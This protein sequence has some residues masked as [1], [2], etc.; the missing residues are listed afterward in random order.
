MVLPLR[1]VLSVITA[2]PLASLATVI[3]VASNFHPHEHPTLT[4]RLPGVWYQAD[5]SPAHSLFHRNKLSDR[6]TSPTVGSST[7]SAAYPEDT[8][9][10][11]QLPQ[12]WVDALDAAVSAGKIPSI[13]VPTMGPDG[14]PV[15]P[16][17][18]D[19]TSSEVC[20][21]TYQCYIPGEL[22]NAPNGVIAASFDDGPLPPSTQL[23]HFLSANDV[24]ATHFMIGLN[25]IQ[26]WEEFNLAVANGDDI[27][28][29]TYTHPY[30]TTLNNSMVLGELG[31]TMQLIHDSTGGRL[32]KYWRP[33]YG[34]TD[35][36]VSAIAKE[37]FGL[38]T[39]LW[40]NDSADW[41][42]DTKGGQTQQQ[43]EDSLTQW[44]EGPKSPGL[45]ILEHE[46]TNGSVNAY[47]DVFPLIRQNG[48]DIV[49]VAQLDGLPAYQNVAPGSGTVQPVTQVIAYNP[50][51]AAPTS[52]AYV[53]PAV[54]ANA[55]LSS[56][57][58]YSSSHSS[59]FSYPSSASQSATPSTH[60]TQMKNGAVLFSPASSWSMAGLMTGIAGLAALFL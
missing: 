33:P 5:D 8:P 44:I 42:I 12:A 31:W 28:V 21:G 9:D 27:A 57:S 7:W 47:M 39:V 51:S 23:Y 2:L 26:Y 38:T 32:P 25:I 41:T 56:S 45:I 43:V 52:S 15:Y 13:P 4:K 48:W 54:A 29:H 17:G 34:D 49:S 22:W 59:S 24:H 6:Q 55:N 20:S 36:R 18:L 1:C 16:D 19:P 11:N 37:V 35:V 46:L 30:T 60:D 14:N 40:N 50:T 3:P 58:S 10:S 53:P